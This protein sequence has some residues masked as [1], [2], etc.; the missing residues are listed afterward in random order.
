MVSSSEVVMVTQDD[1]Q[2]QQQEDEGNK[3]TVTAHRLTRN[4]PRGPVVRPIL[5]M[6]SA[7]IHASALAIDRLV[8]RD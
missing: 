6:V 5:P 8:R 3:E 1:E 2:Q 4:Q 7:A